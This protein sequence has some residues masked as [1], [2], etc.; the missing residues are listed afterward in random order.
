[1]R[2][3][4][5]VN[6]NFRERERFRSCQTDSDWRLRHCRQPTLPTELRP[7]TQVCS[8]K[9]PRIQV[10]KKSLGLQTARM[11]G[12]QEIMTPMTAY[13][14]SFAPP[15]RKSITQVFGFFLPESKRESVFARSNS[16][17]SEVQAGTKS[18]LVVVHSDQ[19]SLAGRN[20]TLP[21][22]QC[23]RV[24]PTVDHSNLGV[25]TVSRSRGT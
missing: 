22:D 15:S 8:I 19:E 1:M 25:T 18:L 2:L 20:P 5:H 9:T 11:T 3:A 14:L 7:R 10:V 6:K 23:A 21:V 17:S 13:C 4:S 16:N 24:L 12:W